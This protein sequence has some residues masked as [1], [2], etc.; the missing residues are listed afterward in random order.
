MKS[1]KNKQRSLDKYFCIDEGSG[2]KDYLA[3]PPPKKSLIFWEMELFSS[4]IKKSFLFWEMELSESAI[5]NVLY[6]RKLN[7]ALSKPKASSFPTPPSLP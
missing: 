1:R 4:N 2:F 3:Q 6:L 5:K 7:P